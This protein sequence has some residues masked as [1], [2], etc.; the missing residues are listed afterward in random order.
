MANHLVDERKRTGMPQN[1]RGSS[2]VGSRATASTDEAT[3]A[4]AATRSQADLP[5]PTTTTRL[6][7]STSMSV[8]SR[9]WIESPRKDE[10]P[11]SSGTRGVEKRPVATTT[12]SNSSTAREDEADA[13]WHGRQLTRQRP[14]AI[15]QTAVTSVAS[16]SEQ[17]CSR[18]KWASA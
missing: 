8:R 5:M 7:R 14:L 3:A 15:W 6:P 1:T 2:H 4:A 10:R 11:R 16:S 18:N 9:L 17:P 13:C 12:M